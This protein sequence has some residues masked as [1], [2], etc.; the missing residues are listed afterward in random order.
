MTR[1]ADDLPPIPE[2]SPPEESGEDV[3]DVSF[4]DESETPAPAASPLPGTTAP[5]SLPAVPAG[6]DFS[7]EDVLVIDTGDLDTAPAKPRPLPGADL[8][9]V[10]G[11][12][13]PVAGSVG[14]GLP[15]GKKGV[16]APGLV[17]SLLMQM[18]LA[19]AIGGFL[20]WLVVEPAAR[21]GELH[22][23]A[24]RGVIGMLAEM[25]LFGAALGGLI[26]LALGAVESVVTGAWR[27]AL[28]GGLLGLV[29]GGVG[30]SVGAIL[31]Q[32]MYSLAGG[33]Q[34]GTP[35]VQQILVRALGWA[36]IG[37]LIG[38]A[39]GLQM[40]AARKVTNGLLGGALG[41]FVGGLLFDP[42]ALMF[43]FVGIIGGTL[44]R[45]VGIV[46]T[47]LCTGLGIGMVEELRKEAW[48]VV[49]AGPLAG[50]QFILY[51]QQTWV[52]SDPG[53]DIPLLKDPSIAPKQCVF[54]ATGRGH[55]VM[56]A[57]EGTTLVNG[58]PITLVNLSS[59]DL[60]QMGQTALEYQARPVGP[61][62][63]KWPAGL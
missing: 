35:L 33:G 24:S 61:V 49:V 7:S 20:A 46:V 40:M 12:Y 28:A 37:A 54:E 29:V 2:P 32:V 43:G 59:G 10:G 6:P 9:P 25:G 23:E 55:S 45:L 47:G 4:D 31:A 17:G 53:M 34:P 19:G 3:L 11:S 63:G 27:K 52:G 38:L 62:P 1:G 44:S 8:P 39:P 26:A 50:K 15:G 51:R 60:I 30:G 13:P 57:G 16:M 21:A 18:A 5:D 22:R 41:G 58:R 48:V 42:I 56:D 36:V 14:W